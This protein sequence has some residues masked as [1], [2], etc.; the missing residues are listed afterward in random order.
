MGFDHS[1]H[2]NPL[3]SLSLSFSTSA[4]PS[5][6][7]SSHE[8]KNNLSKWFLTTTSLR[9]VLR[10]F[11][12][13]AWKGRLF[14]VV[15]ERVRGLTLI[16]SV[17]LQLDDSLITMNKGMWCSDCPDLSHLHISAAGYIFI[18]QTTRL[19]WVALPGWLLDRA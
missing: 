10:S 4:L 5:F 7:V 3:M 16:T 13:L 2:Q 6:Q 9:V 19:E 15:P 8:S 1:L 18:T 12:A 17:W 11:Q 14:I